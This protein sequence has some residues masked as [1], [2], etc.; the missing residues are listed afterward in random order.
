MSRLN[1]QAPKSICARD[2]ANEPDRNPR[3][4][5]ESDR[6]RLADT[7]GSL[8]RTSANSS[9]RCGRARGKRA[10]GHDHRNPNGN[11]MGLARPPVWISGYRGEG[12]LEYGKP[13]AKRMRS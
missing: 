12:K 9:V 1:A 8:R 13:R 10:E 4:G 2:A 6:H 7:T 3:Q 5:S 11:T